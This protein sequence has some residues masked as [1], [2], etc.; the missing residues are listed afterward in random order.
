MRWKNSVREYT[1]TTQKAIFKDFISD[2]KKSRIRWGKDLKKKTAPSK[3]MQR[4]LFFSK[5]GKTFNLNNSPDK[6]ANLNL[7]EIEDKNDPIKKKLDSMRTDS[8]VRKSVGVLEELRIIE[9]IICENIGKHKKQAKNGE[10]K[11]S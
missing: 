6:G 9:A 7:K 5:R 11:S 10:E 2:E 1:A 8:S 4:A 3:R